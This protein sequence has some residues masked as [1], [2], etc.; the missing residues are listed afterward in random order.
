[1]TVLGQLCFSNRV[2]GFWDQSGLEIIGVF[3]SHY[4]LMG[5]RS[6]FGGACQR[7]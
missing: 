6:D 5:E 3:W 7:D 1:M 2:F 4:I